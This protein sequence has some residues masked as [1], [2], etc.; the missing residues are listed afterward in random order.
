MGFRQLYARLI[1]DL[2]T[3]ETHTHFFHQRPEIAIPSR[4]KYVIIIRSSRPHNKLLNLGYCRHKTKR[5]NQQTSCA[6]L[7]MRPLSTTV[8]IQTTLTSKTSSFVFFTRFL[9]RFSSLSR[10]DWERRTTCSGS[11]TFIAELR[12]RARLRSAFAK[13]FRFLSA[14]F[15]WLGLSSRS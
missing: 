12:K 10:S 5:Q 1:Q 6:R 2:G 11:T 15:D 8:L 13:G 4:D 3:Y 9:D 14:S 7:R